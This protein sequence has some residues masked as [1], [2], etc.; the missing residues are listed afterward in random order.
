MTEN[1]RIGDRER[2]AAAERLNKHAAA[3]RLD[4]EELETRLERVQNAV[5]ERD[6]EAVESDLPVP[7]RRRPPER[8][9][10]RGGPPA[11]AIAVL[12]LGISL[13]VAVGH[14]IPPL[15]IL[16]FFLWLRPR[17]FFPAS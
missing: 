12:V 17:R 8:W 16:A 11:A 3:G 9:A 10:R 6:L 4:Y 2:E 7:V 13:S 1:L 15:F 14:P 5:F